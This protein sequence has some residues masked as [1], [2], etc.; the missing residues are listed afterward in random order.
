MLWLSTILC[1]FI[2]FLVIIC[3]VYK[4]KLENKER[5]LSENQKCLQELTSAMDYLERQR[6]E[7]KNHISVLLAMVK[8]YSYPKDYES[9]AWK[10]IGYELP[11]SECSVN[12]FRAVGDSMV[13]SA[14]FLKFSQAGRQGV[15]ICWEPPKQN[16]DVNI[17]PS[18]L[19]E[20][21]CCLIDNALD[22]A[23]PGDK[24]M[25]TMNQ[26]IHRLTLSVK[27]K[28]NAL[29]DDVLN[30]MFKK[31]FSTKTGPHKGI[32][33]YNISKIVNKYNGDFSA[34]NE[35]IDGENFVAVNIVLRNK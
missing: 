20:V 15:D 7:Y 12:M 9:A 13:E 11:Q 35:M 29:E 31:G 26:N 14:L 16:I 4:Q 27:N 1:I 6:H 3:Y 30:S 28:H 18:E 34:K 22:A 32:G 8:V 21:I 23:K 19:N 17:N 10:Y 5:I 2:L 25:V 24:L 33:L